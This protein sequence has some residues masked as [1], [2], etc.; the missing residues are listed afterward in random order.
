MKMKKIFLLSMALTIIQMVAKAEDNHLYV[1]PTEGEKLVWGVPSLQKMS[2]VD[3]N[4]VLTKKD[5]TTAYLPI[6]TVKRMYIST[7]SAEGIGAVENNRPYRWEG[8][9]LHLNA[10]PDAL[11]RI[12][13]VTGAMVLQKQLTGA[14]LDCSILGSGLYVVNVEGRIFKLIKK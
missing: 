9:V 7:P 14:S 3:G 13:S 10:R 8:N 5:G 2:F 6:A 4:V 11:V 1:Q 12:Y